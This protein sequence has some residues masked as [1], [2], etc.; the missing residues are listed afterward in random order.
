MKQFTEKDLICAILEYDD[1]EGEQAKARF[2]NEILPMMS[3]CTDVSKLDRQ[4]TEEEFNRRLSAAKELA[5]SGRE[6]TIFIRT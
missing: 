1:P 2:L 3:R 5:S 6:M 4:M